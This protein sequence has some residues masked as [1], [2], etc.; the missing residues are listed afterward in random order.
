MV[1]LKPV[2]SGSEQTLR[3]DLYDVGTVVKVLK[4]VRADDQR[5][6]VI[7]QGVSRCSVKRVVHDAGYPQ[8]G[9]DYIPAPARNVDKAEPLIAKLR[10]LAE[11]LMGS[12][13][14]IPAEARN[15]LNAIGDPATLTDMIASNLT[16]PVPQKQQLLETLDLEERIHLVIDAQEKTNKKND[17]TQ[18]LHQQANSEIEKVQREYYLKQQLKAIQKELNDGEDDHALEVEEFTAAIAAAN[19]PETVEAAAR[20]ELKRMR[21]HE[22]GF[23]RT[24]CCPQLSGM[25]V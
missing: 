25:D 6:N 15:M 23:H 9:F 19:M 18:A 4:V 17:V 12:S 3:T 11:Q 24:Q 21:Q 13:D 7:L 20:K 8:L 14:S 1:T 16:L 10:E 2:A 5:C 22:S